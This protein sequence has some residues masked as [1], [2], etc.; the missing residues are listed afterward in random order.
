MSQRNQLKE[1]T[2]SLRSALK[3]VGIF[4]RVQMDEAK[5]WIRVGVNH[6]AHFSDEDNCLILKLAKAAGLKP[7]MIDQR[8]YVFEMPA[9]KRVTEMPDAEFAQHLREKNE[10]LDRIE[11]GIKSLRLEIEIL[12]RQFAALR[13]N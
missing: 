11:P 4:A 5:P 6:E 13:P 9:Q 7:V 3:S 8:W 1:K 2:T 12:A 10:T